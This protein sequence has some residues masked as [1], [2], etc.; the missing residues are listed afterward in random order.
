MWLRSGKVLLLDR[1]E[2][3]PL[4]VVLHALSHNY[5]VTC[6][7]CGPITI[8]DL[9]AVLWNIRKVD[10]AA[11]A[12]NANYAGSVTINLKLDRI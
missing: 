11:V 8:A 4:A 9:K 2:I 12:Y 3:E 5:W 7:A 10:E 6:S 1:E